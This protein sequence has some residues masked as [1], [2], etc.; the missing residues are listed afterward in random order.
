[1]GN[2][3]LLLKIQKKDS[4]NKDKKNKAKNLKIRKQK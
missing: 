2:G 4:K 3:M 1:M